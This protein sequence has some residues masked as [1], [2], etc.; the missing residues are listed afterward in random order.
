MIGWL[1]FLSID[2]NP[3]SYQNE[4]KCETPLYS[5]FYHGGCLYEPGLGLEAQYFIDCQWA[6]TTCAPP[7]DD[8]NNQAVSCQAIFTTTGPH[9]LITS[10]NQYWQMGPCI[11][12]G[13][14]CHVLN[15]QTLM[16]HFPFGR[17]K[18]KSI[19]LLL[20]TVPVL[21]IAHDGSIHKS[22]QTLPRLARICTTNL[23]ASLSSFLSVLSVSLAIFLTPAILLSVLCGCYFS[24]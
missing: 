15:N 17:E 5:I 8:R 21:H 7:S 10:R 6:T 16:N 2:L 20:D 19:S 13:Q 18:E 24:S 11:L 14:H 4:W 22:R 12:I 9:Q 23:S 1:R 3:P